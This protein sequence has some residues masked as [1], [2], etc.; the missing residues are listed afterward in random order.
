MDVVIRTQRPAVSCQVEAVTVI[1]F[2][3]RLMIVV[4]M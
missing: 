2:V 1:P 4:S 3:T